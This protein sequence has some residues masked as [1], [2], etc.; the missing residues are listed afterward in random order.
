MAE[1]KTTAKNKQRLAIRIIFGC[2]AVISLAV[3]V[4]IS[5]FGKRLT[6]REDKPETAVTPPPTIAGGVETQAP[7][8]KATTQNA[9]DISE[10]EVSVSVPAP[11]APVADP[12][13]NYS[14]FINTYKFSYTEEKGVTTAVAKDN[15]AVTLTITPKADT[16][17]TDLCAVS[18]N[19]HGAPQGGRKL[20]IAN[21]N[22]CYSSQKDGIVTTVICVDDGND[23]SI[24]IKYRYPSAADEYENDFSFMISM[25]KVA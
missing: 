20:Q 23:G 5:P 4:L 12:Y 2:I 16:T 3:M 22:T 6:G 14:V 25:F 13:K 7:V 18:K 11:T 17:Y 24:E 10:P 8:T 9:A 15:E 1:Q 21:P 19:E